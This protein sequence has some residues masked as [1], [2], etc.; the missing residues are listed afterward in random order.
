MKSVLVTCLKDEINLVQ[1]SHLVNSLLKANPH[2]E[3]SIL[4]FKD[5]EGTT[6][7]LEGAKR[8]FFID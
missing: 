3:L 5:F 7:I 2:T 1:S 8:F 6:Q 4:T